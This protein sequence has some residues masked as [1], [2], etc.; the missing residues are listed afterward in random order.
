MGSVLSMKSSLGEVLGLSDFVTKEAGMLPGCSEGVQL[1]PGVLRAA[2]KH[3]RRLQCSTVPFLYPATGC[4]RLK[5]AAGGHRA[6]ERRD[7][8][9]IELSL[10]CD[11]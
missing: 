11:E 9:G 1:F 5:N 2:G 3:L 4:T 7:G 10:S 8:T 6:G